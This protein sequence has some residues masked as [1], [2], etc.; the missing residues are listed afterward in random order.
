MSSLIDNRP[1][2]RPQVETPERASDR[3]KPQRL[4]G[5]LGFD[6]VISLL[7]LVFVSGAF[8]D[9]WAHNHDRVDQSFF[10][11]WHAFLYS[12]FL[13]IALLLVATQWLNYRSGRALD[14]T[15]GGAAWSQA[16][17]VGYSLSLL[18]VLIFAAGGVGDLLWHEIFGIE[19]DFDALF[20]PTHLILAIGMNLIVTGPLRAAWARPGQRLSWRTAGPALLSLAAL[21]SGFTFM[22]MASHP[23]TASIA[24]IGHNYNMRMGEI[25]GTTSILLTTLLL[26]GPTLLMMRRWQLPAGSLILVWGINTLAMYIVNLQHDYTHWQAL[27]MFS[28]I[29]VIEAIRLGL[30]PLH[31][32][33]AAF[34]FFAGLAPFLLMASYFIALLMTE[35]TLWTVHMWAGIVVEAGIAGWLLSYLVLPP[36]IPAAGFNQEPSQESQYEPAQEL[37]QEEV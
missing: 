1:H 33:P 14:G 11:P 24:G 30:E 5:G 26:M 35:G 29:L 20:S 18:G 13:V 19:A 22:T 25:A 31:A 3:A 7:G 27:A 2:A 32:K 4:I 9:G 21:I 36:A 37:A 10:T 28:A 34:H 17:P 8:L 12:G 6:W 16:L 23:L 15:N